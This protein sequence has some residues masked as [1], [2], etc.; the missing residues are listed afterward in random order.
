MPSCRGSSPPR[1][2][3]QVSCIAGGFFTIWATR[4]AHEYW[5]GLPWPPLGDLPHSGIGPACPPLAGGFF[6]T[7]TTW[8]ALGPLLW[9]VILTL[10]LS[11]PDNFQQNCPVFAKT[12]W[13][14]LFCII[15]V[16]LMWFLRWKK[17][18]PFSKSPDPLSW[19]VLLVIAAWWV[20]WR[21]GG[22]KQ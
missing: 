21:F 11:L 7:G 18:G 4:E 14:N 20:T 12:S 17:E 19:L 15:S 13:Y 3:T 8:K 1:D 2:L 5:S 22:L 9:D 10:L 16:V 6:T